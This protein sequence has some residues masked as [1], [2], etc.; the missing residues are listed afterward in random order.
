MPWIPRISMKTA[1]RDA[2][3]NFPPAHEESITNL[4]K[5][6]REAGTTAFPTLTTSLFGF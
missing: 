1:V 6:R 4:H 5:S 3:V 2:F